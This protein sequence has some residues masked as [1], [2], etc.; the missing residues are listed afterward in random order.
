MPNEKTA[1]ITAAVNRFFIGKEDVTELAVITLIA[2]GH[3]LLEDVPGVGKTTLAKLLARTVGCGFSRVQC[4]PDTLPGDITG[5]SVYSMKT[6]E[7]RFIPGPVLN[8]IVLID[9][10]NRT[11]PKTQSALLEAMQE[12]QVTV[13]RESH[14]LP[15]P[16]MVIAT[17]NPIRFLGTY[18]L[19]EAQLDRFLMRLSIGYPAFEDE[20]RLAEGF[21]Q[22]EQAE[23]AEALVTPEEL[24]AMR[25][26]VTQIRALPPLV[27]YTT[28]L[29]ARTRQSNALALGASP[30]ATLAL[31]R[32]AQGCA[33][34]RGRGYVTP[35]DVQHVFPHV[36]AHR[37]SLTV[38]AK[39]AGITPQSILAGIVSAVKVPILPD[40]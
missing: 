37:L 8:N 30:R 25:R 21:L 3:L 26:E 12:G 28:E 39:L 27:E 20:K 9:E 34:L 13:D 10:I 11:S 16:F 15:E 18:D 33:Y 23:Q 7:F 40:L 2:G 32:A 1:Q 17:Q 36:I 5:T 22:G 14:P 19:P 4:T 29:V 35:D 31:I 24:T 6:G 38:E